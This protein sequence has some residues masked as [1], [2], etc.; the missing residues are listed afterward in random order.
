[1]WISVVCGV[2]IR[3][4]LIQL[5]KLANVY[6]TQIQSHECSENSLNKWIHVFRLF[7]LL[8]VS[9]FWI[10]ALLDR[11]SQRV[12]RILMF[13]F[14]W[15]EITHLITLHCWCLNFCW[16]LIILLFFI[17]LSAQCKGRITV[18][19]RQ[20]KMYLFSLKKGVA[21]FLYVCL[22]KDVQST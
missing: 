17:V 14:N 20:I 1:M 10:T 18:E 9:M 19:M 11:C 22:H 5:L 6:V 12:P 4:V 21:S 13:F 3:P 16:C 15:W 8:S 2:I 7:L